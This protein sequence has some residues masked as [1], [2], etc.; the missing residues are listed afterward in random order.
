MYKV[1]ILSKQLSLLST[2]I[3]LALGLCSLPYESL[4]WNCIRSINY[5]P[6]PKAQYLGEINIERSQVEIKMPAL[7]II[8]TSEKVDLYL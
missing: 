1:A 3:V 7:L 6:L 4:G 5:T 2:N 8:Y